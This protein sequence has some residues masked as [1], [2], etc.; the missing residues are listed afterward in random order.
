MS[1]ARLLWAR[2]RLLRRFGIPFQLNRCEI[3]GGDEVY[4]DI[5][6]SLALDET[7]REIVDMGD[8]GY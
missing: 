7:A 2:A 4:F 8:V 3:P 5:P 6:T 1:G